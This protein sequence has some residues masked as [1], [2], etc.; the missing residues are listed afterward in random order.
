MSKSGAALFALR[1]RWVVGGVIVAAV[2]I[3]ATSLYSIASQIGD[4]FPGFFYTPDRIVSAF[5]PQ[6]FTGWQAGLRPWD[7]IVAVNGQHWREMR[8]L[9]REAGGGTSLVYT[10]ERGDQRLQIAVPTMEFTPDIVWRFIAGAILF[11]ICSLAVGIFVYVR[12]PSGRLNR[13]LLLYLLAWAGII[14]AVWEVFLSQQKWTAYLIHP[15]TAITA[16]AGWIF[17]WSFPADRARK[18]FLARWPLI[19]AFVALALAFTIYFPALF[20]LASYLDDPMLWRLYLWSSTWGH[21]LILGVGSLI[22]NIFS[23]LHVYD[24]TQAMLYA[25]RKGLVKIE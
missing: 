20:F 23:K 6:D 7:R 25:I 8:R 9:V 15:W 14:G 2:L 13:Y 3:W 22:N 17:F 11:A 4:P 5:T 10:V 1:P 16:V 19:P 24:R 18:E 21:F 12:N